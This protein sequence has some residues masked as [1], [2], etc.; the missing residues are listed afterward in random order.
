MKIWQDNRVTIPKKLRHQ[1]GFLPGTEV[2]FV[3]KFG[4]LYLMKVEQS[5][6]R[7]Q[8]QKKR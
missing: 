3:T 4:M 6:K 2:R 8:M 5:P 1:H 7:I